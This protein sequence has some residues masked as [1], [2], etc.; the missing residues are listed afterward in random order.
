VF[1]SF[2][3]RKEAYVKALGRG[4]SVPLDQFDVSGGSTIEGNFVESTTWSL[5]DMDLGE[6]YA[7][8][9]VVEGDTPAVRFSDWPDRA[10]VTCC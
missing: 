5:Q 6:S 9:I 10:P 7:G 3:T 1:Y 2:W 4:L 8:A